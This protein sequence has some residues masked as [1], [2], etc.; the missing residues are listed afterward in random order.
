MNN[1]DHCSLSAEGLLELHPG[2]AGAERGAPV[3]VWDA[4]LPTTV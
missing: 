1:D 4:R 3:R 2:A